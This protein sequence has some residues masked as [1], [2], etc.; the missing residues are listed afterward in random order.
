[1]PWL[2][3]DY[4]KKMSVITPIKWKLWYRFAG[5]CICNFTLLK[6]SAYTDLTD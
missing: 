6:K 5:N 4:S 2:E 3:V 1:M